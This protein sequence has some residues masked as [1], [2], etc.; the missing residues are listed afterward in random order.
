MSENIKIGIIADDL[1]G[2]NDSG[3]QLVK[4]GLSVSVIFDQSKGVDQYTDVLVINTDSR[5][6]TK[7]LSYERSRKAASFLKQYGCAHIYKKIDSTL[8]GN[9]GAELEAVDHEFN[10]DFVIIAPAFPKIG[11]TTHRGIHYL[12]DTPL[13]QTEISRDPKCP[14]KDANIPRLLEEQSNQKVG[15]LETGKLGRNRENWVQALNQFKMQN[16]KWI[17]CDATKDEHLQWITSSL[18]GLSHQ[19]VW[20]GSAGLA[21]YLPDELGYSSIMKQEYE[22]QT[23][24][25][26]VLVVSGSVSQITQQQVEMVKGQ[27]EIS[28]VSFNPIDALTNEDEWN[29]IKQNYIQQVMGFLQKSDCVLHVAAGQANREKTLTKGNELGISPTEVSNK[30]SSG[31]GQIASEVVQSTR[32]VSGLV[33]TG[34]DTATDVCRHLGGNGIRL[35]KEVE[36]GI[37]LGKLIGDIKIL[38]ITKAGAFGNEDSLVNA[39]RLLKG[40]MPNG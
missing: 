9:L 28:A 29:K 10:P 35:Y 12:N 14:V 7:E 13:D 39:V 23:R 30:I 1:T 24:S 16:V 17:V 33:L 40:V 8:R 15:V 2:A 5:A 19:F 11:R 37:P 31:L 25:G 34:G 6:L 4:K 36:T 3:V 21:E 26:N 38:T 22:M 20:V 32:N 27:E 18:V